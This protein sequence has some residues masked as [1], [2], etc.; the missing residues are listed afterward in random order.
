MKRLVALCALSL[1][2]GA[3]LAYRGPFGNPD[4]GGLQYPVTLVEPTGKSHVTVSLEQDYLG[5]PDMYDGD[6]PGYV[7]MTNH[8][9]PKVTSLDEFTQGNPDYDYGYAPS[10]LPMGYENGRVAASY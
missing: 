10:I 6:I 2:A 7:A 3:A 8:S 4:V 1:A 5:N 9:A